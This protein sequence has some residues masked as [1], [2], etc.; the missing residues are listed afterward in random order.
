MKA[1]YCYWSVCDGPYGAM[2][3]HCV[4]T[5]RRCGVFKEFHVL[6]DRPLAGCESYDAFQV[7]KGHHLF[8]LHYL[9]VGMS[10]LNFDWFVWLD[11]DTVFVR[12]PMD[13]LG[14]LGRSPLHVPLATTLEGVVEGQVWNGIPVE[15]VRELMAGQGVSKPVHAG[16]SAFWI[17]HHDAIEM[18]Y[19]LAMGFWH[20]AKESGR[21]LDVSVALS[22]AMQMLCADVERHRVVARPDLWAGDTTERFADMP[23]DGDPWDWKAA[24]WTESVEVRPALVHLPRSREKRIEGRASG[25]MIGDGGGGDQRSDREIINRKSCIINPPSGFTLIEL[26]VVIAIIGILAS[27]LLPAL[28]KAKQKAQSIVCLGNQRQIVMD[29]RMARDDDG[30]RMSGPA[31]ERWFNE[32][33]AHSN[34]SVWICPSAPVPKENKRENLPMDGVAIL[35]GAVDTAYRWSIPP[36]LGSLWQRLFVQPRWLVGSYTYNGW[37]GFP[38]SSPDGSL[39]LGTNLYHGPELFRVEEQ[40]RVAAKTPLIGDGTWPF[41]W[42][43]ADDMPARDLVRGRIDTGQWMPE[44]NLGTRGMWFLCIPR[45]GSRPGRIPRL[46]ADESFLPGAINFGFFDG[47]A[48]QVPLE[49]LWQLHWHRDY[50]PPARRPGLPP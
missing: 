40:I 15:V 37:M 30:G 48:E 21:E 46:R 26:L 13:L 17:A 3:E 10:R 22:Y 27:L 6:T 9:K 36:A 42:P 25:S 49:R 38:S 41:A 4:A 7:E 47:H 1:R 20:K 29:Y 8:K 11:A 28:S 12:Q 35:D 14:C 45:H 33:F 2:M 39:A 19:D 44:G 34:Q 18:V 23:P 50:E 31:L 24:P 43:R 16:S 32:E 5:A